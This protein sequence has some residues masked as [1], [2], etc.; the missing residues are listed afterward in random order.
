L[1]N[2]PAAV[3]RL[4]IAEAGAQGQ[5]DRGGKRLTPEQK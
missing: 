1:E 3:R 5:G 4:N 2:L